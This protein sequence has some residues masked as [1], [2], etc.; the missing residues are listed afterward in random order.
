MLPVRGHLRRRVDLVVHG[1]VD[2]EGTEPSASKSKSSVG[3][4]GVACAG[5]C[6]ATRAVA[7]ARPAVA[8]K[9][10]P[11]PGVTWFVVMVFPFVVTTTVGTPYDEGSTPI[12]VHRE[13]GQS[14]CRGSSLDAGR[15]AMAAMSL[16]ERDL[17]AMRDIVHAAA[18]RESARTIR[19]PAAAGARRPVAAGEMRRAV[20]QRRGLEGA[21]PL[22]RDRRRRQLRAAALR[23]VR[24]GPVRRWGTEHGF[25]G[26]FWTE[27]CSYPERTGDFASITRLSDFT[28]D[29][30]LR[31]SRGYSENLGPRGYL[32][33]TM[34]VWPDGPG[35]TLR[36]LFFRSPGR[37]FD[38]RERFI[39]ELLRPH[40]QAAYT[41]PSHRRSPCS[42]PDAPPA[43]HPAVR[44]R[45]LH[46]RPDRAADEPG[47]RD[48]A[49]PP[50][51]D[52]PPPRRGE[53]DGR[54]PGISRG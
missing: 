52:L 39:L 41:R 22:P 50:Q 43:R 20:R 51:P 33:E 8:R 15:R 26:T 30:E 31:R 49:D 47:R 48:R 17:A 54:R 34:A 32:H 14:R 25:W 42:R 29:R 2:G 9:A 5:P 44:G 3:G 21:R 45:R 11:R 23:A 4:V 40:L 1:E 12:R 37:D 10:A 18:A 24:A 7:Q 36:V 46:E 6:T 28:S 27:S 38:E 35:R 16:S 13:R 53:P 19:R